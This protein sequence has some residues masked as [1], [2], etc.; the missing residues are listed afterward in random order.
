MAELWWLNFGVVKNRTGVC[1]RPRKFRYQLTP[2]L[3]SIPRKLLPCS[4][5]A[6]I[7][8]PWYWRV[9]PNEVCEVAISPVSPASGL[10]DVWRWKATPDF[11][12]P[13]DSAL[14]RHWQDSRH[15]CPDARPP[16]L[17]GCRGVG[18]RGL[19]ASSCWTALS[20]LLM[21][22]VTTLTTKNM[23]LS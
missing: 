11:W 4:A 20:L 8:L 3:L 18:A 17:G 12:R 7:L 10:P 2:A 9:D 14:Q 1:S 13:R 21:C 19:L 16:G 6:S 5:V 15:S 22:H 23:V